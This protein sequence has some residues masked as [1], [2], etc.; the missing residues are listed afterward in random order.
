[1][2]AEIVKLRVGRKVTVKRLAALSRQEKREK[3]AVISARIAAALK[4]VKGG[5]F[6]RRVGRAD[7]TVVLTDAIEAAVARGIQ[8]AFAELGDVLAAWAAGGEK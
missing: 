3:H 1:M 6:K 4:G 7:D 8:T 2:S 5:T